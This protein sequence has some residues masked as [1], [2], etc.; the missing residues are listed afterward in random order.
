MKP[1]VSMAIETSC[2]AGGVALGSGDALDRTIAFDSS[3]RHATQVVSRARELLSDAGLRPA[4]LNELYVSSG[5]GSFTGLRVGVTVAR[6]LGQLLPRLRCV[7]VPTT[8]AVAEN[9]RDLDW[10]HLGVIMDARDRDVYA[11]LFARR[12]TEIAPDGAPGVVDAQEFLASAPRPLTL[13]GEGLAHHE[14]RDRGVTI[15]EP[16]LYL[17]TPEGVWRVGRRMARDGQFTPAGE[18]LPVYA[19]RPEAVRLWEK[20]RS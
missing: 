4:D 1:V 3:A 2:R 13:V 8:A 16:R 11:A 5:P 14:L 6:T 10:K 12:A 9:A 19:R 18:L 17:P 7:G 15:A 20:R